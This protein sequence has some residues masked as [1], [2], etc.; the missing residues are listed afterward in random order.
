MLALR[1]ASVRLLY[2]RGNGH[3]LLPGKALSGQ[4][5]SNSTAL[6]NSTRSYMGEASEGKQTLSKEEE[7]LIRIAQPKYEA[8][9]KQHTAMPNLDTIPESSLKGGDATTDRSEKS[10]EIRRKRL[11]YRSKQRGWLEVDLLLGTWASENVPTLDG[12][13]L[14]QYE[15]FVNQETI[16]I[17]NIITLRVDIPE[18]QKTEKGNSVVERIQQWARSSPLGKADPETYKRVKSDA[19]LI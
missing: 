16:D 15:N 10:L 13:E 7:A 5:G 2:S 8:I 9:Y 14:D 4:I 17:Y 1:P 18:E 6:T 11:I 19:N 12:D 3:L